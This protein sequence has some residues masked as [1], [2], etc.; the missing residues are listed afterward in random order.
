MKRLR[1]VNEPNI[2]LPVPSILKPQIYRRPRPLS[3]PSFGEGSNITNKTPVL[4]LHLRY[5][6]E[7]LLY[8]RRRRDITIVD[9]D[10]SNERLRDLCSNFTVSTT[11]SDI[12]VEKLVPLCDY[13]GIG[14]DLRGASRHQ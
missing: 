9:C 10:L 7:L 8:F 1:F 5:C 3:L 13:L 4:V 12:Q 6:R 11:V 14:D 2:H